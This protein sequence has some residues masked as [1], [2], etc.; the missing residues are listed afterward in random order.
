MRFILIK[1][2]FWKSI[3][4][5]VFSTACIILMIRESKGSTPWS[6]FCILSLFIFASRTTNALK[7]N[8]K[9]ELLEWAKS[10]G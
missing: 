2:G 5:D 3:F 10:D 1:E 8:S 4:T 7:F 6:I 9:E